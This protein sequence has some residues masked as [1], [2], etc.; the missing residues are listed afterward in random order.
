[1]ARK[2]SEDKDGREIIISKIRIMARLAGRVA[3][4]HK[5]LLWSAGVAFGWT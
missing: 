3:W 4:A 1:M 2:K 5:H